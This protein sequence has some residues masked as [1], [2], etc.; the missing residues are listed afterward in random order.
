MTRRVVVIGALPPPVNGQS[1][2]LMR[3]L[4][5]LAADP[6]LEVSSQNVS[7]GALSKSLVSHA[8]KASRI[9]RAWTHLKRHARGA[10]QRPILYLV[11]DGGK[12]LAYTEWLVKVARRMGYEIALQ[13]RTFH[14]V[15]NE[16]PRM[17][18]VN[19]LLSGN[20]FHVFLCDRMQERFY[21]RY[22]ATADSV[23]IGNQSQYAD[24]AENV[25]PALPRPG[26]ETLTVGILSNLYPSKG[27]DTFLAVARR[28][29]EG[30]QDL[31][32]IIAGPSPDAAITA[33]MERLKSDFPDR[34]EIKGGLFG[35]DK[36]AF[37]DDLDIFYF[38]TRY[39][40]EAQP[41]VVIE[42]QSHGAVVLAPDRGC[43]ASD[44]SET[45]WLIPRSAEADV[46][47]QA[48]MLAEIVAKG[49][50]EIDRMRESSQARFHGDVVKQRANYIGFLSRVAGEAP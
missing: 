37:F 30:G 1:K 50:P 47:C 46:D 28:L 17:R 21:K 27:I 11:A 32:F 40:F 35:D 15:D 24:I 6:R 14:Y 16:N 31:R 25:A 20:G 19:E 10:G 29:L 4:N 42:A 2:N 44:I 38:P 7:A 43:I 33:E 23:I 34:T 45:G 8:R 41:N 5:D 9:L 39:P 22:G 49:R 13:H 36:E 12:G 3:I 26:Q 18:K 48:Q